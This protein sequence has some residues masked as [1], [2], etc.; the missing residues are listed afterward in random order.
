MAADSSFVAFGGLRP[1]RLMWLGIGILPMLI[2]ALLSLRLGVRLIGWADI[3]R[4]LFFF[5]PDIS[6][7]KYTLV[8]VLFVF[9][10]NERFKY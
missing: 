9:T 10:V 5:D 8:S 1:H 2:S 4:A 6:Y 7:I 3:G